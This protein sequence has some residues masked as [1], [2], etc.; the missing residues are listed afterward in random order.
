MG[1]ADAGRALTPTVVLA[2]GTSAALAVGAI[3]PVAPWLAAIPPLLVLWGEARGDRV[4]SLVGL[5]AASLYVGQD[6]WDVPMALYV[7]AA[8]GVGVVARV[9]GSGLSAWVHRA[10]PPLFLLGMVLFDQLVYPTQSRPGQYAVFEQV[11]LLTCLVAVLVGG[12]RADRDDPAAAA[13][14]LHVAL[15]STALVAGVDGLRALS[16]ADA[17]TLAARQ[18]AGVFGASNYIAALLAVAAVACVHR[19]SSGTGRPIPNVVGALVFVGLAAPQESRTSTVVLGLVVLG[20]LVVHRRHLWFLAALAGLAVVLAAAPAVGVFAR[21]RAGNATTELNGRTDLWAIALDA[22]R[23]HPVLG[24]GAG[25]ISD[26]LVAAGFTDATYVHDIWLS[27]VV[28]FGLAGLVFLVI[29]VR[30]ILLG[31]LGSAARTLAVTCLLLSTTEP[32]VETMKMGLIFVA[33]LAV[34]AAHVHQH[35]RLH[36]EGGFLHALGGRRLPF[37][38]PTAPDDAGLPAR[39]GGPADGRRR[40]PA[41]RGPERTPARA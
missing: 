36:P 8:A 15:V 10:I 20:V 22:I 29:G 38:R 27:L 40:E 9:A 39:P 26:Q 4:W 37:R 14:V 18:A 23:E 2:G 28:Q 11:V 25:H 35:D 33:V 24:S 12:R 13:T 34:G 21:F 16:E 3:S 5:V 32:V 17:E 7:G 31:P 30:W 41:E 1:R 19:A 6:L